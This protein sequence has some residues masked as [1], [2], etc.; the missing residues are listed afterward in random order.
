MEW[1]AGLTMVMILGAAAYLGF[2]WWPRRRPQ[3]EAGQS[4]APCAHCATGGACG[5]KE[6]VQ[7]QK[8]QGVSGCGRSAE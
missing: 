5:L 3:G 6:K 2:I 7:E 4:A 8:K 1:Q